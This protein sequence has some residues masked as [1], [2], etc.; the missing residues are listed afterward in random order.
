MAE[1]K[2]ETDRMD[3]ITRTINTDRDIY[4]ATMAIIN[5]MKDG[6]NKAIGDIAE[7]I[8]STV[9]RPASEL[10]PFISHLCHFLEEDGVAYAAPGRFG[11]VRKGL[12]PEKK[13][14]K[15]DVVA[16]DSN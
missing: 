2:K 5:D 8:S 6:T 12:R 16:A 10:R 7:E 3:T 11:G 4:T 9:S 13:A 15:T 14:K 1:R